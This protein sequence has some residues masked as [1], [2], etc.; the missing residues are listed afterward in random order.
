MSK[1]TFSKPIDTL[2]YNEALSAVRAAGHKGMWIAKARVETLKA[3]LKGEINVDEAKAQ[4][5]GAATT[6]APFAA[7]EESITRA[8]IAAVDDMTKPLAEDISTL[9]D[10][11]EETRTASPVA[12]G[13][14]DGATLKSALAPVQT[15]IERIQNDYASGMAALADKINAA[16]AS[17][18]TAVARKLAPL[19]GISASTSSDPIYAILEEFAQPAAAIKPV[20]IL[21]DAGAGK[22]Y[23]ARQW[24]YDAKFDY[25]VETGVYE[26]TD[27][28]DLLGN[29]DPRVPW[30]DGPLSEAYRAAAAGK[31]VLLFIDEFY[32]ARRGTRQVLLTCTS[33]A[34]LP[35]G[36]E[37]YRLRTGRAIEDPETGVHKSE[38][39]EAPCRNLAIVATTNVGAQYDVDLGCPAERDRFIPV[40]VENTEAKIRAV[41]S[42]VAKARAFQ[43]DVVDRSLAFWR[44]AKVLKQDGFIDL[45][46][47]TR[48]LSEAMQYAHDESDVRRMLEVL[49]LHVWV[50]TTIDGQPEPEQIKRVR[51]A[52]DTAF[53]RK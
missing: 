47:T 42:S 7:L 10:L 45:L 51:N 43:P 27:T 41:L 32:R 39:I 16:L 28:C 30:I 26:Q 40:H 49:G 1:P 33:K 18:G 19:V 5:F 22:T 50:A 12:K 34:V 52:L 2:N 46:P 53:P 8:A 48:I 24:R 21:G 6:V 35:S 15:R 29:P 20:L 37:V 17:G 14:V 11:I 36:E 3:F 9:R 25:Y 13:L 4:A 44:T 31:T 38:V 23:A